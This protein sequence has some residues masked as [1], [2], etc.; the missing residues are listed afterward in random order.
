LGGLAEAYI[1]KKDYKQAE[2][3]AL[4]SL[5][6]SK[7]LNIVRYQ[8]EMY[9]LLSDLYNAEHDTGK[10]FAA[11]KTY[12]S[13]RDSVMGED[14][15]SE[16][17]RMEMKFDQEKQQATA[18]SEINRQRVI[19]NAIGGGGAVLLI[20]A[21]VSFG[22]YKR[23]RDAGQRQKEA[24]FSAQVSDTEMKAL[25]AQMN[26]HFIFNSLNS[27][28]NYISQHKLSA[29]DDYLIKFSKLMR[30]ILENSELKQVSLAKD[31]AALELYMQL[32]ALRMEDKFSYKIE[33]GEDIDQENTLIPPLILQPFV[34]NSIWHGIAKKAGKGR[35]TVSI[36]K[37]GEMI[38]CVVEDNG[39]GLAGAGGAVSAGAL[40]G[41]DSS[42]GAAGKKIL[43]DEDH[44][45]PDRDHESEPGQ[46]CL[47]TIIGPGRRDKSRGYITFGIKF[48]INVKSTV[49]I[50]EENML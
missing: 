2:K 19:R 27:I 45:F 6:L 28:G 13:L 47:G 39:V 26:P 8:K 36:R 7:A 12:I 18:S 43:G 5:E 14:K 33:V 31:L 15:K 3:Y 1:F 38:H 17:V 10:A 41:A 50:R 11:Y 34:E 44:P 29:A 24:E 42:L 30:S 46:S 49:I 35:I 32:E 48:L 22:F 9:Q 20:A 37:E 25:R 40:L 21:M 23:R 4:A 16:I